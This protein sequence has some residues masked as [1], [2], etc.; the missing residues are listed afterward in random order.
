VSTSV[1][2]GTSV[3][4]RVTIA[5]VLLGFVVEMLADN[6]CQPTPQPV[7]VEQ[8]L[9]LCASQDLRVERWESYACTCSWGPE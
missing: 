7:G 1:N 6:G 9:E 5:L 4:E 2:V 3:G 8:C